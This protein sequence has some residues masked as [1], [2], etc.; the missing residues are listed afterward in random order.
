MTALSADRDIWLS[1]YHCCALVMA[2]TPQPGF[3][4]SLNKLDE[5][6]RDVLML[7]SA[8]HTVGKT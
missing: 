5:K 2:L 4:T 3:P 7:G 1:I 6:M 8:L